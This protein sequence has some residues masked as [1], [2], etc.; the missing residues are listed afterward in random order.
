MGKSTISVGIMLAL[1]ERGFDPQPFKS[2]PDFLDPMHHSILLDRRSRNLDTWMFPDAVPELFARASDGAGISVIEGAM[3]LYDG[4]DGRSE[5]GST[6]H[7]SKVLKAPVVLVIDASA[8]ARSTGAVALGFSKYDEDVDIRA[9][10]FN[11]VGGPRHLGMLR[12]S[13]RGI[14]CLGGIP[15]DAAIRLESRHLGLVPAQENLDPA[16]YEGIRKLIEEHV[17]IA[18]LVEI[19][20]SAPELDIA[21]PAAKA[22]PTTARIGVAKDEAFNFYYEDNFQYL[23]DAGAELVFFSPLR[24][25]IPNVDG[26]YFGGGYPELFSEQLAANQDVR[27]EIKRLS[28]QGMPIYAECGGLM[29]MCA[30]LTGLD[31]KRHEMTGVFDAEVRMTSRLQELGYVDVTAVRDN[32]LSKAGSSTRGH[33]FHYSEVIDRG[34]VTFAYELNKA[35]GIEGEADGFVKN[36]TLASYAHLHFGSCPDWAH[37][38]VTACHEYSRSGHARTR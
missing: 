12:D 19:A 15:R 29:Y 7:L 4:F 5:E 38:F 13:L 6:A 30:G 9:V 14:E 11:N 3:G 1:K 27:A 32:I 28:E 24:D 37:N 2:G 33:V 23:R 8:S 34:N 21:V 20:S 36:S 10:I 18:R 26:L 35:K 16:R 22:V 17:D 25:R 31:G